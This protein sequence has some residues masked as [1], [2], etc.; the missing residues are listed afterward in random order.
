MPKTSEQR[1]QNLAYYHR[2]RERNLQWQREYR[3]KVKDLC[4]EAYGGY[5]CT[6]C[7]VTG[8]KFLTLDHV[9]NDGAKH[10][11]EQIGSRGGIGIYLWIIRNNFPPIFQVLCFNCNHAKQLNGGVC[12]HQEKELKM[13][14]SFEGSRP[15]HS[16]SPV[17]MPMGHGMSD[18]KYG[19]GMRAPIVSRLPMGGETV[20]QEVDGG[21]SSSGDHVG[22]G[23][24]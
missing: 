9:N 23:G 6:C 11:K 4:Y 3:R 7:G 14:H 8:E 13:G 17:S 15:E 10:R 20:G 2:H 19:K 16:V 12:P 1:K 5:V 21:I 18:Q 22:G 24:M